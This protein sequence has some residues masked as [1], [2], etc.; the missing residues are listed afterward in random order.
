MIEHNFE[1]ITYKKRSKD[2]NYNNNTEKKE[3][4][5]YIPNT[6]IISLIKSS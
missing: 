2:K 6:N 4:F 3:I 1:L 5:I